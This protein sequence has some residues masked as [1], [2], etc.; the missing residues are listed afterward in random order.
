MPTLLHKAAKVEVEHQWPAVRSDWKLGIQ[1]R[2]YRGEFAP[3]VFRV[4]FADQS[5]WLWGH[6]RDLYVEAG[7]GAGEIT[8]P[9]AP[10]GSTVV[11]MPRMPAVAASSQKYQIQVELIELLSTDA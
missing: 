1:V 11:R 4:T 6:L 9:D 5:R 3:R 2:A 7:F 8:W 10:G